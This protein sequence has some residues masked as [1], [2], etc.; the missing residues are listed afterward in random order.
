LNAARVP[1]SDYFF[2]NNTMEAVLL[3]CGCFVCLAGIMFQ[4]GNNSN[5]IY[6]AQRDALTIVVM[7][8]V[9]GSLTYFFTVFG[10]EVMVTFGLLRGPPQGRRGALMFLA[11]VLF[12]YTGLGAPIGAA[13]CAFSA[14]RPKDSGKLSVKRQN[15]SIDD[16]IRDGAEN[17][18]VGLNPLAL[19]A[20]AGRAA[21]G[22][23]QAILKSQFSPS[24][25]QWLFVKE[26]TKQQKQELDEL[27]RELMELLS[28][29]EATSSPR[30][31]ASTGIPSLD[32]DESGQVEM[33]NPMRML[34]SKK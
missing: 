28:Q 23:L 9:F 25:Q 13:L 12:C 14:K 31:T 34:G 21:G 5:P 15:K 11:G 6:A 18:G 19:K 2:S 30:P 10:T 17:T 20:A 4:T 22:N 1:G 3:A 32:M 29:V 16:A 8:V 33:S 24:P 7:L 27:E 26:H